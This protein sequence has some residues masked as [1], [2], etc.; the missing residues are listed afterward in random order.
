MAMKALK[1][2]QQGRYINPSRVSPLVTVAIP[3]RLSTAERFH[4]YVGTEP[5][6]CVSPIFTVDDCLKK[7]SDIGLH[8]KYISGIFHCQEWERLCGFFCM[9]YHKDALNAQLYRNALSFTTKPTFQR[10]GTV[11]VNL[12]IY[13][14]LTY[15]FFCSFFFFLCFI[16]QDSSTGKVHGGMFSSTPSP[17]KKFPGGKNKIGMALECSDMGELI[18]FALKLYCSNII[19]IKCLFTMRE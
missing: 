1:F 4:L 14:L 17:S 10:R 18:F 19:C 16:G 3:I 9:V 15:L 7:P 6:I 2:S 8:H 13:P 12:F 11:A 5:A